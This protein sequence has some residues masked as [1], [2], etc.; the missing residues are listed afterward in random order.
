MPQ[1]Q[2][3]SSKAPNPGKLPLLR[4]SFLDKFLVV[5]ERGVSIQV[6]LIE[7]RPE[8]LFVFLPRAH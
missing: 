3:H 8:F 6:Q 5:R 4:E 2:E 7:E 1:T